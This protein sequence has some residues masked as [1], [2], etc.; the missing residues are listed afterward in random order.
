MRDINENELEIGN[1]ANINDFS[2]VFVV[3][4]RVSTVHFQN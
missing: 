3:I 4:V 2:L 1:Y